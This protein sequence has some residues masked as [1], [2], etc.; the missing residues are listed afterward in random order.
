MT[1][2]IP[3]PKKSPLKA[4]CLSLLMLFIGAIFGFSLKNFQLEPS[5]AASKNLPSSQGEVRENSRGYA[6]VNPLL[7]CDLGEAYLGAGGVRPSRAALDK[8]IG[9]IKK[10]GDASFVA[11][12]FRD[13]NNGPWLGINEREPFFPASLLKVPLMLSYYKLAETDPDIFNREVQIQGALTYGEGQY[14]R[15][16]ETLDSSRLYTVNELIER[17]VTQSDNDAALLLYS[18]LPGDPFQQLYRDL[19]I[20][21]PVNDPESSITV[22]DYAT[23]FRVLFNASYLRSDLSNQALETLTKS[24]FTQGLPA[25]LPKE[26]SV[27]HKFGERQANGIQ[28]LHDCGIVYYPNHPYLLCIMTRGTDPDRQTSAIADIS[29]AVFDDIQS[30]VK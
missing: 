3:N 2:V 11:L 29:K 22:R 4:V 19:K 20:E 25:Q 9:E 1:D 18:A 23:F 8:K 24:R 12:Y 30:Q 6:Y 26:I 10:K 17:T 21:F 16:A 15:P 5:L 28:Q 27:A 14:F 13:L 7:E